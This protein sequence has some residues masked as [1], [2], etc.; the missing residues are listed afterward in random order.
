[1]D[2]KRAQKLREL[3]ELD[4]PQKKLFLSLRKRRR[5]SQKRQRS[6]RHQFWKIDIARILFIGLLTPMTPV[7][8]IDVVEENQCWFGLILISYNFIVLL[9]RGFE[10]CTEVNRMNLT[11]YT[12]HSIQLVIVST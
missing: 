4:T 5:L 8:Q 1:M 11:H 6:P 3:S 9:V 7:Q 2:L 10:K 12:V